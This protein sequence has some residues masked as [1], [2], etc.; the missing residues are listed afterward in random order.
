MAVAY[1]LGELVC[2]PTV[3][4]H[5]ADRPG[6]ATVTEQNQKLVDAF[7]VADV[8]A[9]PIRLASNWSWTHLLP[10]LRYS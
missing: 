1:R 3:R 4:V 7:G 9:I 10:E 8:E 6:S 5:V 2:V